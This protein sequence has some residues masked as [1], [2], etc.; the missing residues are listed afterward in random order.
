SASTTVNVTHRPVVPPVP[1]LPI[2]RNPT[3]HQAVYTT[4]PAPPAQNPVRGAVMTSP[5]LR[6]VTPQTGG[7]T[8]R[9]PQTTTYVVNNGLALGSG[10]PQLTVHHRPP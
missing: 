2:P 6:P 9:M 7:M 3:N 4:I 10:A 5:G 1:K 8:V